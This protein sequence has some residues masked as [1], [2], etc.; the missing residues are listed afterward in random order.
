MLL[1]KNKF[2]KKLLLFS[3]IFLV[4]SLFCN[5]IIYADSV[6][7]DSQT[8]KNTTQVKIQQKKIIS[9]LRKIEDCV[10]TKKV[11]SNGAI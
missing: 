2:F 6:S 5:K 9:S 8:K 11:K 4:F 3:T 7:V 1:C 10:N